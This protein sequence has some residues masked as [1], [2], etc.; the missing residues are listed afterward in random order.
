MKSTFHKTEVGVGSQFR[1]Q[2]LSKCKESLCWGG[3]SG[4]KAT[5]VSSEAPDIPPCMLVISGCINHSEE[6]H[7]SLKTKHILT[8]LNIQAACLCNKVFARNTFIHMCYLII[9]P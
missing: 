1:A 3:A 9:I 6:A 2:T 8:F 4:A 5:T 7:L